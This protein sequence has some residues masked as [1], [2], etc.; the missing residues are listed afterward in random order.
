MPPA[1]AA[2]FPAADAQRAAQ[3]WPPAAGGH[4]AQHRSDA[5][6][7]HADGSAAVPAGPQAVAQPAKGGRDSG[8]AG[9]GSDGAAN[10]ASGSRRREKVTYRQVR[11]A[12]ASPDFL[13]V[14][15]QGRKAQLIS[16]GLPDEHLSENACRSGSR[17]QFSSA[18]SGGRLSPPA[19]I[20][21]DPP[22]A[23]HLIFCLDSATAFTL[24]QY[25]GEED[26][27][28]VMRLID[29]ELSEPYSIFTYRC[30]LL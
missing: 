11:A 15:L 26:L 1:G 14:S 20:L 27:P 19:C 2:H 8:A 16:S 9:G 18:V 7:V 3:A 5:A 23:T 30:D 13:P 21:S 17:K 10:G 24:P 28:H 4:A 6:T 25:R 29:A 12:A 22:R